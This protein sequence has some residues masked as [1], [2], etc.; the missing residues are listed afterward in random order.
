MANAK[1][2][3]F[4]KEGRVK[5]RH[6]ADDKIVAELLSKGWVEQDIKGNALAS[7]SSSSSSKSS[8]K[9]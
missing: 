9:K 6:T 1:L 4:A 2:R 3:H 5:R 8:S 7:P